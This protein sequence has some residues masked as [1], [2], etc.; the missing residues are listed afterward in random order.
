MMPGPQPAFVASPDHLSCDLAGEAVI[1]DL[2]TGIYYGLN[3]VGARVW[4]LL[5]QPRTLEE[6]RSVLE[7]EYEVDP[8]RC[9]RDLE[10]LIDDLVRRRLI[11]A[12]ALDQTLSTG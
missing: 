10:E 2:A 4:E 8:A 3:A 12:R 6:V 11:H 7:S 5:Q 1:L 9:G